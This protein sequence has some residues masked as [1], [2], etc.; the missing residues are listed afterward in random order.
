MTHKYDTFYK[1]LAAQRDAELAA[2]EHARLL[3][4]TSTRDKLLRNVQATGLIINDVLTK[5][6]AALIGE[7][8]GD[9]PTR[10]PEVQRVLAESR[11]R[12]AYRTWISELPQARMGVINPMTHDEV[13]ELDTQ[14][15]KPGT[16]G[17]LT[18]IY[19]TSVPIATLTAGM[20]T[21]SRVE[22]EIMAARDCNTDTPSQPDQGACSE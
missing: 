3:G 2:Y 8:M 1:L 4:L 5:I 7:N 18:R 11:R 17:A 10:N 20:A 22:A 16:I 19:D 15:R 14:L 21:R 13:R 12:E 6:E 9:V